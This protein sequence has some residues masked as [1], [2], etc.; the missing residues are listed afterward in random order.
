VSLPGGSPLQVTVSAGLAPCRR[1]TD[2]PAVTV[3]RAYD[4]A[5]RALYSAKAGGRRQL[6]VSGRAA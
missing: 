5:D 1:Q 2:T 6:V 3:A 4:L